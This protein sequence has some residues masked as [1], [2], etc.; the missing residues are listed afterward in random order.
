VDPDQG[1]RFVAKA[2][3]DTSFTG[4]ALVFAP[5][6]AFRERRRGLPS[7]GRY[8]EILR[9]VGPSLLQLLAASL[10]L[11]MVGL[12]FPVANQ[13]LVDRILLPRYAPW[14]WGLGLGLGAAV[15][16]R[17]LLTLLRS[18]LLQGLQLRM[19]LRL[20]ESFVAHLVS[21]PLAFFLQRQPGDLLNRVE[22]NTEI[23]DLLSSRSV[24]ALLDVCLLAGYSALMLFYDLRLA[25]VVLGLAGL[26]VA[27]LLVFQNYNSQLTSE[28]A[29]YGQEQALL[30]E[31]LTGL[32]TV[33]ASAAQGFVL[34]R[35]VPR[36]VRRM[37]VSVSR[38]RLLLG[39]RQFLGLV[40]GFT[41]AAVF[42][43]GGREV[44]AE[45]M[46]LGVFAAFLSLQSLFMVPLEALLEAVT[47]LQNLTSH[48]LR[49]DDVLENP[50]EA[51]GTLDPGRL[52]GGITLDRVSFRYNSGSPW[53]LR[54]ISLVIQPGEKVALVG[55]SGAGKSTLAKLL[56]GMVVPT[57]GG[58]RFDGLEL[59]SLDLQAL[60]RQLGVVLQD[61][62][63]F[64]EDVRSNIS[65][66]DPD[67]P[68]ARIQWAA[69]LAQVHGVI[70]NLAQGYNTRM[71][72]NG[73][74][75]SGG[76]RQRICLAR[77]IAAKPSILLLDEATSALDLETERAVHA[78]LAAQGYTR[79]IIAHR[80]E[81][82]KDAD[83]ILVLTEGSL[84]QQG[85]YAQLS[86][87]PGPFRDTIL[88][89]AGRHD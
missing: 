60:R 12:V 13:I 86:A 54:D 7:L 84:A 6:D 57:E 77:A 65:L 72:E 78:G 83:R 18:Y 49:L 62:F 74:T 53:I 17:A 34:A 51:S 32:E 55:Q 66:R 3:L 47:G 45:R 25:L 38:Q 39:S 75:L 8:L 48:L 56:M 59:R 15:V 88:A 22:S 70:A 20:M 9:E 2:R 40:H 28:L 36:M 29:F 27:L 46:T 81:T 10:M 5:D 24:S 61:S 63:L 43:I 11:Q 26:R 23:R 14:L 37:N 1:R 52:K 73:R 50:V 4:V 35:W 30:V 71:G 69:E 89:G 64:D 16:A 33:Q 44:L 85:T 67:M 31:A 21:L 79:I 58:I 82:V 42:W 68:M 19:D 41:L 76:E 80:L 87:A